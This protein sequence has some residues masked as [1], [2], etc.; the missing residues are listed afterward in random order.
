MV[1]V[2]APA[3]TGKTRL[4]E[5]F[6]AWLPENLA[7]DATTAIAQCLPYGQQLTYWPMRQV[8]FA[9]TKTDEDTPPAEV[10]EAIGVWLRN[11]GV[12][13]AERDAKLIAATIGEATE[14]VD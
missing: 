13:N 4:V 10:R 2:I 12:E 7:R 6:L 9:L 5:E 14:G 1:S 3:G 11:I 8:V